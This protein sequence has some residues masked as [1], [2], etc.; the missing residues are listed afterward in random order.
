MTEQLNQSFQFLHCAIAIDPGLKPANGSRRPLLLLGRCY[1]ANPRD[2][3]R[4][5]RSTIVSGVRAPGN[6]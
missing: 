4:A 6:R 2:C 1:F 5:A 3:C